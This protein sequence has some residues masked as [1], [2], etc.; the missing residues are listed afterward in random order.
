VV[1]TLNGQRLNALSTDELQYF[2]TRFFLAPGTGTVYVDSKPGRATVI[3]S[4]TP[5]RVDKVGLTFKT[6]IQP[7]GEW[8]TRLE[9][10][11]AAVTG[12]AT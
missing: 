4:S 11:A 8:E 9:V 5:A 1:L 7:H 6:R 10:P 12:D 3:S 2:E